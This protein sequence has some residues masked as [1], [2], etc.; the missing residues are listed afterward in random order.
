MLMLIYDVDL[1]PWAF[2]LNMIWQ[3]Q[4]LPSYYNFLQWWTSGMI[5]EQ[6]SKRDTGMSL[7]CSKL[8]YLSCFLFPCGKY[9][10][11]QSLN[12]L[13]FLSYFIS[14]LSMICRPS[15]LFALQLNNSASSLICVFSVC[16]SLRLL[17]ILSRNEQFKNSVLSIRVW[18][19]HEYGK[20]IVLLMIH[21]K[22][23]L[24]LFICNL[25]N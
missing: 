17:L 11:T 8:T 4:C 5:L 19:F 7:A 23:H 13:S 20:V 2:I 1:C 24:V 6:C 14:H 9:D 18:Y 12:I 3:T 15:F 21:L 25:N 22:L 16:P 10:H